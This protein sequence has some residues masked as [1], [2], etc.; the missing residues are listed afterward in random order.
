MDDSLKHRVQIDLDGL[1]KLP[2]R[3]PRKKL[4][5]LLPE[6]LSLWLIKRGYNPP[7]T[8]YERWCLDS[9]AL[10]VYY[11]RF[12]AAV[13]MMNQQSLLDSAAAIRL[14]TAP[15]SSELN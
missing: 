9:A 14:A 15:G 11:E 1:A 12:Y 2:I 13:T 8:P 7:P 10:R 6:R 5:D 3:P 4:W